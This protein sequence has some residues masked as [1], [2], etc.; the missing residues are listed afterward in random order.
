MQIDLEELLLNNVRGPIQRNETLSVR[1]INPYTKLVMEYFVLACKNGYSDIVKL[2]I[3]NGFE[4][5]ECENGLYEAV[6]DGRLK[7][8]KL[9]LNNDANVHV[10]ENRRRMS[11]MQL[12]IS[13]DRKEVFKVL[14]K[15]SNIN[16]EFRFDGLFCT[17]IKSN[18]VEFVKLLLEYGA[19]VNKVFGCGTPLSSAIS[20]GGSKSVKFAKLL[21]DAGAELNN[22][23]P[24]F[25]LHNAVRNC[26]YGVCKLLI[27]RGINVNKK[28]TE[29][30]S[31]LKI[32]VGKG[33]LNI[34]KLLMDNGAGFTGKKN[35]SHMLSISIETRRAEI[36]KYLL[37]K[38]A[39]VNGKF[40]GV[41][42]IHLAVIHSSVE[43]VKLL[44]DSGADVNAPHK[45]GHTAFFMAS[46]FGYLPI[47]KYLISNDE[48]KSVKRDDGYY[49]SA[50]LAAAKHVQFGVV[51]LLIDYG[52]NPDYGLSVLCSVCRVHK[53][54]TKEEGYI[55]GGTYT[56]PNFSKIVKYLV[57]S[58]ADVQG[59][60][61]SEAVQNV[62]RIRWTVNNHEEYPLKIRES[63]KTIM[64][65]SL[66]SRGSIGRLPKEIVLYILNQF[67]SWC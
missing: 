28:N 38:G 51:K 50:L 26:N 1:R 27:E 11:L 61:D 12:A 23:Y 52:A 63:V 32:A 6:R 33:N 57:R 13:E 19:N 54:K 5:E 47:V 62:L 20:F 41:K 29:G 37:E 40:N 44:V 45:D 9:L 65:M 30:E 25:H 35:S 49:H 53:R 16:E 8:V 67:S 22:G 2:M 56:S 58:G 46:E 66:T 60:L 55:P 17:A 15:V 4:M 24:N 10:S 36:V 64:L 3:E 14:A 21:L 31:P 34:V 59:C 39:D 43:I 42:P 48:E 7:V 18:S